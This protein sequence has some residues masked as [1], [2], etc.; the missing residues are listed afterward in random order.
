MY[1]HP[2]VLPNLAN[3]RGLKTCHAIADICL[4]GIER[5]RMAHAEAAKSLITARL[6]Q[7]RT[8]AEAA[9]GAQFAIG[10]FAVA[11][12][13]PLRLFAVASRLGA[14]A[15]DTHR[16]TMEVLESHTESS[17][18]MRAALAEASEEEPVQATGN[19]DA[20]SRKLQMMG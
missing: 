20:S 6:E 16:Q 15:V 13:E 10:L 19:L 14:I 8:L 7:A 5:Q 17:T 4:Q 12:S 11:A 9:D 1:Y 2:L 18:R 3:E